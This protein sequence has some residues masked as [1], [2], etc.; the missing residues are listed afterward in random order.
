MNML[1]GYR[2]NIVHLCKNMEPK[3]TSKRQKN[4][5]TQLHILSLGI[6][7]RRD[8]SFAC[9]CPVNHFFRLLY[10][11]WWHKYGDILV[12]FVKEIG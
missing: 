10:S 3:T 2:P 4:G 8:G 5:H 9:L 11:I 1:F 6:L 12:K 7:C